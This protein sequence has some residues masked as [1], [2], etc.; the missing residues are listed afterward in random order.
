MHDEHEEY[1]LDA[2]ELEQIDIF[3]RTGQDAFSN[4][5]HDREGG[6]ETRIFHKTA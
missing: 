5:A 3:V 1:V 4:I 6:G 2:G